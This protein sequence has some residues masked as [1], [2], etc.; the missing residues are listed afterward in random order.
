MVIETLA[1]E[2][3][4]L[5]EFFV[6]VSARDAARAAAAARDDNDAR[7]RMEVLPAM[8]AMCARLALDAPLEGGS[9]GAPH[10]SA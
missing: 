2:V 3:S 6:E 8:L 4:A 7:Q 10:K 1:A 5:S 9:V